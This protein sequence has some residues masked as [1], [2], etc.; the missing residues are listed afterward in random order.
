MERGRWREIAR[1]ADRNGVK[2]WEEMGKKGVV[3]W[4][5]GAIEEEM[6]GYRKK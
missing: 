5:K 1:V 3:I 4:R 2:W 6:D